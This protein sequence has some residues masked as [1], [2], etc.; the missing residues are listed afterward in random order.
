MNLYNAKQCRYTVNQNFLVCPATQCVIC[1]TDWTLYSGND[2]D[3]IMLKMSKVTR[4][5]LLL[6]LTGYCLQYK[7]KE[8]KSCLWTK[9]IG[10]SKK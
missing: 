1:Y 5:D 10:I 4:Q 8:E 6:I 7:S 9:T 2:H 3:R